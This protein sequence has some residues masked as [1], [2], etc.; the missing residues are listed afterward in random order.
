MEEYI[1]WRNTYVKTYKKTDMV[2]VFDQSMIE[3]LSSFY[4]YVTTS[5]AHGYGMLLA[6]YN[7][8]KKTYISLLKFYL[9]ML[10]ERGLMRSIIMYDTTKILYNKTSSDMDIAY[11]LLIAYERWGDIDFKIYALNSLHSIYNYNMNKHLNVPLLSDKTDCDSV[12]CPGD[13]ILLYFE[14]FKKYQGTDFWLKTRDACISIL[15]DF[16]KTKVG[17]TSDYIVY[18]KIHKIWYSPKDKIIESSNDKNYFY[19]SCRLPWR[20]SEYYRLYKNRKVGLVLKRYNNF[21]QKQ[22]NKKGHT[23]V[24]YTLNGSPI[25]KKMYD[26]AFTGPIYIMYKVLVESDLYNE[27][28]KSRMDNAYSKLKIIRNNYYGDTI[29]IVGESSIEYNKKSVEK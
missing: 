23:S 13:F 15:F 14:K 7:N 21:F 4:P 3:G 29:F 10:N 26:L 28:D 24:G 19:N 27:R 6:I 20:L 18:N 11:S 5:E 8:D 9:T 16:S 17:L 22:I 25:N 1:E 2:Y 12:A